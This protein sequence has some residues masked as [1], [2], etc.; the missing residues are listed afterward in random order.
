VDERLTIEEQRTLSAAVG[1][2][3][4]KA[5]GIGVGLLLA[6]GLFAA[7]NVLIIK[8]GSNVG[9]HLQ[10]LHVY[11]PGYSVTFGG[12]LIGFVYAFVLGYLS[13]RMLALFYYRLATWIR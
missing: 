10:L 12:S 2:A 6:T 1:E 5:W 9:S 11:F 13:G 4:E 3:N 7:T 8:G